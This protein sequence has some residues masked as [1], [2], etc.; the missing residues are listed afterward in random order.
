MSDEIKIAIACSTGGHMVQAKELAKVYEMYSHFYFTFNG[1]V[2]DE[3]RK[4]TCVY[5]IP[6]IVK[7]NPISWIVGAI[8]SFYFALKE[9]PDIVITTGAGIVVFF[10]VFAKL[11]GA[12]LIFIE[13][14]ARIER[15]TLTARMLYPFADLFF[16][17]WPALI[18][19]FPKAKYV[20]RLL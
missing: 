6:N 15:P 2:A 4:T 11:F 14:M 12:K 10:C 8:L 17:Q 3:M 7:Y 13:S 9:R 16:V 5:S 20:G 19:F 1:G 18:K